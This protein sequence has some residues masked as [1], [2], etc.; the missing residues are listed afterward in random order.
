MVMREMFAMFVRTKTMQIYI[1]NVNEGE[2]RCHFEWFEQP[3]DNKKKKERNKHKH[4]DEIGN[5]ENDLNV[6][7]LK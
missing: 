2:S 1:N 5:T 6:N 4:K 3:L 7:T